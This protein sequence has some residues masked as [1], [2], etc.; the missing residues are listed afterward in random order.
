L[1]GLHGHLELNAVV[2]VRGETALGHQSFAAPVHISKPHRDNGW[3]IV[4]MASP[5]PGLLAGDTVNVNVRVK[6]GARLLLTAPSASRIHTMREGECA[7]VSQKFCVEPGGFLDVW[8]EY[9]IPQKGSCYRQKSV[10]ELEDS[11]TLLW[12][13]SIAP[14][15]T[16]H[17]EVFEFREMRI[18][19]DIV[20]RGRP[21]LR[22]RYIVGK[23]L[24]AVAAL[25]SRFPEAYY[26]SVVCIA[27]TLAGKESLLRE[28]TAESAV[29]GSWVGCSRL[30]DGAFAA[31][32]LAANSPAL[33]SEIAH[34]RA[35]FQAAAGVS[36]PGLRRVTGEGATVSPRALG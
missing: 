23:E 19:T 15:R 27:P 6:S 30:A 33:R 22:E 8:P 35:R 21:V 2:D 13:E 16:A 10:V 18:A 12:T 4:N 11:A 26:A 31:K 1:S 14:G 25:R 5:S 29:D 28:L 34:I 24:P 9:V 17:G 7:V 20:W 36:A 32:I 3:L